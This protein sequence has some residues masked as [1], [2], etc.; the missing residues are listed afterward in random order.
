MNNKK[1]MKVVGLLAVVALLAAVLPVSPVKAAATLCVGPTTEGCYSTIQAAVGAAAPGDMI[2]IREGTYV[3]DISATV[4]LNFIGEVN[5]EGQPLPEIQGTLTVN[6]SS[7]TGAKNWRIENLK[8][9]AAGGDGLSL[10]S[11]G[12]LLVENSI[13]NGA[14]PI[15]SFFVGFC[16]HSSYWNR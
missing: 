5:E 8:F 14:I 9:T 2:Y 3:E 16:R 15:G 4:P 12:N 10:T 6:L 1:L 11:V 7:Y 13:F